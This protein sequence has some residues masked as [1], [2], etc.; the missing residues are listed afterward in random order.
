MKFPMF[1]AWANRYVAEILL[2]ID[3]TSSTEAESWIAKALESHGET[4]AMW[5]LAR[6]YA[7][8]AELLKRKGDLPRAREQLCKAIE[9]FKDCGADGWVT[10]AEEEMAKVS[11]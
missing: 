4:N 8:Y 2:R 3:D 1:Q 11:Q 10:K 6:D 7:V 5:H 9:I